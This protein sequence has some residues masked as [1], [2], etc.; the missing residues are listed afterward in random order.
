MIKIPP[1]QRLSKPKN[2]YKKGQVRDVTKAQMAK[3]IN[4]AIEP[5]HQR[6][7]IEDAVKC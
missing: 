6:K 3:Q 1:P 4:D 2:R 5:S 7:A